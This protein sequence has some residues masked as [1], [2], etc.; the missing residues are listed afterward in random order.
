LL[1]QE[2]YIVDVNDIHT[3]LL[4]AAPAEANVQEYVDAVVDYHLNRS[5][6]WQFEAFTRGFGTLCDG[7]ALKLL[8][9]QVGTHL[10]VHALL[11]Y[12]RLLASL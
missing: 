7:P 12:A 3:L 9:P 6:S 5:V 2:S 10:T 4:R 11:H 8:N 1:I